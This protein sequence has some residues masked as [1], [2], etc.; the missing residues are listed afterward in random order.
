MKPTLADCRLWNPLIIDLDDIPAE[1]KT[2]ATFKQLEDIRQVLSDH[3]LVFRYDWLPAQPGDEVHGC[4]GQPLNDRMLRGLVDFL[5]LTESRKEDSATREES[6]NYWWPRYGDKKMIPLGCFRM[7]A[8]YNEV[9][10]LTMKRPPPDSY[11]AAFTHYYGVRDMRSSSSGSTRFNGLSYITTFY[12]FGTLINDWTNP[13]DTFRV[14]AKQDLVLPPELVQAHPDLADQKVS[15]ALITERMKEVSRIILNETDYR[16]WEQEEGDENRRINPPKH[17]LAA[18]RLVIEADCLYEGAY[19]DRYK[20]KDEAECWDFATCGSLTYE[21]WNKDTRFNTKG[22]VCHMFGR[23]A[24]Q[25]EAQR[26]IVPNRHP[27]VRAMI[28]F[29][30]FSDSDHD[31]THQVYVDSLCMDYCHDRKA[32]TY[33]ESSCT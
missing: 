27:Y 6:I 8:S 19:L 25:Q 5:G 3:E 24:S 10:W 29:L 20:D 22:A 13:L 17:T 1:S 28:P 30:N 4:I 31:M 21:Q 9:S 12:V 33:I 32:T 2:T 23:P 18:P 26:P 11:G 15:E 16:L 14:F 7:P